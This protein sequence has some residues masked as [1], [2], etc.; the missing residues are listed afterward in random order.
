MLKIAMPQSSLGHT[1]IK[2]V[3][4]EVFPDGETAIIVPEVTPYDDVVLVG[5]CSSALASE[6]FLAAAYEI[7]SQGPK[8]FTVFNTY[9]RHARSERKVDDKATLAKFQARLWSGLGRIFPGVRVV[10]LDLHKDLIVDFFEG[11]VHTQNKSFL[12]VLESRVH[13]ELHNPVYA[14]V[15]EGGKFQARRLAEIANAG[16]A[17][18]VK[19]RQSGTETKILSVE[20]DE[21]KDR[22]VLIIDDMISTGGSVAKAAKAYLERG[23]RRVVVIAAHGIFSENA[24]VLMQEAGVS[25]VIVSDSHPNAL[26]CQ[27]LAP[28]F[29]EVVSIYPGFW[30]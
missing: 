5:E 14:T 2:R 26:R 18:I 30:G 12:G 6:T 11:P 19:K 10:L 15:D 1:D 17:S 4:V 9:F 8:S 13:E 28:D 27:D 24:L 29:I 23:A 20:G 16:F 3:T 22:D 7:A 21:V 25:K